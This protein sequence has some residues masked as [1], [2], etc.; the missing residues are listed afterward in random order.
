MEHDLTKV[1][2]LCRDGGT[3]QTRGAPLQRTERSECHFIKCAEK[4][5]HFLRS[6]QKHGSNEM[7]RFSEKIEK[8][9]DYLPKFMPGSGNYTSKIAKEKA[10]SLPASSVRG[11]GLKGFALL[12]SPAKHPASCLL[13]SSSQGLKRLGVGR[14]VTGGGGW[15]A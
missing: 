2:R 6:V 12:S 15:E 4:D 9:C 13:A 11:L 3:I 1:A 14:S 8:C 7:F 5:R 10:I